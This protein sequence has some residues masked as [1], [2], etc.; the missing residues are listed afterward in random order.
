MEL[1]QE[2]KNQIINQRLKQ[3]VSEKFN[4]ELNIQ[5]LV[6]QLAHLPKDQQP[7]V[8]AQIEQTENAIEIINNA[9]ETTKA[10]IVEEKVEENAA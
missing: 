6:D 7:E 8:K 1:T 9:I 3:F 10:L 4:H 5:I 2:E